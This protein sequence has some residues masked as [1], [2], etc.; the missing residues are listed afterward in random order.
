MGPDA[1]LG[2]ED[3]EGV[4]GLRATTRVRTGRRNQ[5]VF[6]G[7]L[8]TDTQVEDLREGNGTLYGLESTSETGTRPC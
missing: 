1:S 6:Y 5:H 8:Y 3:P 7:V 2:G 4:R